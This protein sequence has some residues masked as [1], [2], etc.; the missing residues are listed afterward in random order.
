MHT[1]A[2]ELRTQCRHEIVVVDLGTRATTD[3][4]GQEHGR[5]RTAKRWT[6]PERHRFSSVLGHAPRLLAIVAVPIFVTAG[7]VLAPTTLGL[8]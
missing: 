6:G 8:R 1:V 5:R 7:R 4:A 2:R 3:H